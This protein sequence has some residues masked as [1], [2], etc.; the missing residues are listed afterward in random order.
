M[1]Q[2]KAKT[3]YQPRGSARPTAKGPNEIEGKRAESRQKAE[4]Q[5]QTRRSEGVT[6]REVQPTAM[7][8]MSSGPSTDALPSCRQPRN[9][10][11]RRLLAP[12][13]R[14]VRRDVQPSKLRSSRLP[15]VFK[16]P[17]TPASPHSRISHHLSSHCYTR[18]VS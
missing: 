11:C 18:T 14:K 17:S 7:R 3:E 2:P 15:Q 9:T 4:H 16:A 8:E 10:R 5:Q 13:N 6:W 1:H 12:V